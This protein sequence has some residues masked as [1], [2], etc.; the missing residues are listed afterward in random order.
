[1][2]KNESKVLF[3]IKNIIYMILIAVG[4]RQLLYYHSLDRSMDNGYLVFLAI[5]MVAGITGIFI[6]IY[7]SRE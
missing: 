4:A 7:K 1:M 6:E 5:L 2:E 3:A